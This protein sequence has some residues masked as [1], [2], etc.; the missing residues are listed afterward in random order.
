MTEIWSWDDVEHAANGYSEK[1][2]SAPPNPRKII[3]ANLMRIRA[4]KDVTLMDLAI[5]IDGGEASVQRYENGVT[6][7]PSTRLYRMARRLDVPIEAMFE[8]CEV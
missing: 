5:A 1:S 8:G 7:I 4:E 6:D 2:A 3:A